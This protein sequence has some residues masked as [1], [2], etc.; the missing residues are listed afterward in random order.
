MPK[1]AI[2]GSRNYP[3]IERVS[4]TVRSQPKG[5][6]IVSGGAKGVDEAA[7][8]AARAFG[9]AIWPITVDTVGLPED[10]E[11]RR[12]EYGKRAYARNTRIAEFADSMVAFWTWCEIPDC[13]RGPEKHWTHGTAHVVSEAAR[14]HKPLR[15][16]GP[17]GELHED[18]W[19][20]GTFA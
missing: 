20:Y 16:V 14:L 4:L 5:T 8:R 15:T 9:F 12:Q 10:P 6:V 11:E 18:G 2:V 17:K 13:K 7:E 1:L 19:L 3:R